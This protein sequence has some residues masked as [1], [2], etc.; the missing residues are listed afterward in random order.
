MEKGK[1]LSKQMIEA[2][3]EIELD[4]ITNKKNRTEISKAIYML[5]KEYNKITHVPTS[6]SDNSN[7][8]I[9]F[10]LLERLKRILL[11]ENRVISIIDSNFLALMPQIEK[12]LLTSVDKFDVGAI[13]EESAKQE[14]QRLSEDEYG[15]DSAFPIRPK[16]KRANY[17]KNISRILKTWLSNNI[18]KPYPSEV[19]KNQLMQST[20]L[21]SIQINNWFIN[22]RRR[23]LPYMKNRYTKNDS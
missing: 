3:K 4:Y 21:N 20:G 23:I 13:L 16:H 15:S 19:E 6:E 22:A 1:F 5:H 18:S 11:F 7:L 2:L 8:V 14:I 10:L 12:I 17:P 9:V